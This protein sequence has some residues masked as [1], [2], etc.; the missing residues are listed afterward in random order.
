M[1]EKL[2]NNY[3]FIGIFILIMY[4]NLFVIEL[5]LDEIWNYGFSYN[6]YTGLIPYKD[7]NL[8]LTPLFPMIM[9]YSFSLFGSSM[10][11]FHIINAIILTIMFRYIYQLIGN[12]M[13]F[14]LLFFLLAQISLPNYNL[15]ILF[16]L[17]IILYFEKEN[18]SDLLIGI[19]IGLSILTKQSIGIFFLLPSLYYFKDRKKLLLR[20]S[21]MIIPILLFIIYLLFTNSYKE[22]I[23][24]CIL[25][26]FDFT[27]NYKGFNIYM[28]FFFFMVGMTLYFIRKDKRDITNYYA[29]SY[30]SVC[31]PLFDKTHILYA[32]MMFLFLLL[33]KYNFRISYKFLC[34]SLLIIVAFIGYIKFGI[35]IP[36]QIHHF[37][38]RN[39]GK[40]ME[41]K[42]FLISKK[43][44][45]YMDTGKEVVV[46]DGTGYYLKLVNKV[47]IQYYDLINEGNF[48]S[49]GS[50]KLLNKIKE[51]K[52]NL[53]F[54]YNKSVDR[55]QSQVDK[56]LIDYVL[57][58]GTKLDEFYLY[59]IYEIKE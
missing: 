23:D 41:E 19:L 26:L 57:K 48:G 21:G 34:Y 51:D 15:F 52:D 4:F 25:G 53:I 16:L 20:F 46:L 50:L 33:R 24:L 22:F 59:D 3:K 47:P 9:G 7:F 32:G 8:V 13:Y 2:E 14:I 58:F 28:L 54:F 1:K 12:K 36:N 35:N 37:E 56:K 27:G 11:S 39:I 17:I 44:Q 55:M 40:D 30:Y 29:L 45:Y 6:I 18:K 10:L 49:Q 38:Y 43:I 31:I 42:T 5:N